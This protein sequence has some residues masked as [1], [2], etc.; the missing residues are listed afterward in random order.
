[1]TEHELTAE[2]LD[3]LAALSEEDRVV[4]EHL[5]DDQRAALADYVD[6]I[7]TAKPAKGAT[8]KAATK[9]AAQP[10]QVKAKTKELVEPPHSPV[11]VA[12]HLAAGY[13]P[14]SVPATMADADSRS[15][16]AVADPDAGATHIAFEDGSSYPIDETGRITDS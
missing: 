11:D 15:G 2:Q 13:H 12:A 14:P 3:S 4:L 10:Q 8:K 5:D 1:M 16:F 7:A 6:E 9:K